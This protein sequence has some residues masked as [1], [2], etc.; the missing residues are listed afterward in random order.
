[1]KIF[2]R[3]LKSSCL[4]KSSCQLKVKRRQKRSKLT[5]ISKSRHPVLRLPIARSTSLTKKKTLASF[6][7]VK[8]VV[9]V[10]RARSNPLNQLLMVM[11]RKN[12]MR[13][14]WRKKRWT[15]STDGSDGMKPKRLK[16]R[17][18]IC[19]KPKSVHTTA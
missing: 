17:Q 10:E 12:P 4:P 7:V 16:W 3:M 9:K 6:R 2:F 5:K 8:R 18:V 1:M 14:K 11:T 13:K 15:L 19:L